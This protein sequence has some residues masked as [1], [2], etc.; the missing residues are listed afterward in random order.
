MSEKLSKIWLKIEG[1]PVVKGRIDAHVLGNLLVGLQKIINTISEVKFGRRYKRELFRLFLSKI[2]PGSVVVELESG[3]HTDL[4][5]RIPFNIVTSVF[6]ELVQTLIE[7]PEQFRIKI[8]KLIPDEKTKDRI[9]LLQNLKEIWSKE[10]KYRVSTAIKHDEFIT[11]DPK[12]E[13]IIEKL[14]EEYSKLSRITLE[15]VIIRI[16]GDDPVRHFVIETTSGEK[17]KCYYSPEME[18]LVKEFYKRPV[19]VEGILN[20]KAKTTEIKSL[21]SIEPFEVYMAEK[22]GKFELK[23]PIVFNVFYDGLEGLWCLENDELAING[24]GLTFNDAIDDLEESLE[25][26]IVGFLAFP[27][28]KLHEKSKEI[29]I[30]LSKYIDIEKFRE[31]YNPKIEL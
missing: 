23:E 3:Y 27:E 16:K 5:G 15:G 4:S 20:K 1:K 2:S 8:E 21:E 22:I 9:K 25:S 19:R 28:D 11:L 12:R 31:I 13:H 29:K 7:D 14:I 24:Y 6:H 10:D 18:Q 26:L 17:V 30:K